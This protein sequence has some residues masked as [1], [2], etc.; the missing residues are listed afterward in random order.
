MRTTSITFDIPETWDIAAAEHGDGTI[1]VEDIVLG[2][3]PSIMANRVNSAAG[4]RAARVADKFAQLDDAKK[5]ELTLAKQQALLD[6]EAEQATAIE[7]EYRKVAD[8][9]AVEADSSIG[10]G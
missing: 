5:A 4:I 10:K 2:E 9:K 6:V 3:I 7:T 8:A 1:T